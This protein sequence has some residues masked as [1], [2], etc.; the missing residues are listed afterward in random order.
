MSVP[1]RQWRIRFVDDLDDGLV[2]RTAAFFDEYFPGVFGETC[3]PELFRWK[4][5]PSNPAG[6]GILAVAVADDGEET[7]GVM[8]ATMKQMTVEGRSVLGAEVGDSFTNPN[9]RRA[10]RAAELSAG[11]SADH[12]LNRSVFGRLVDEVRRSLFDQNVEIVYG[13]PNDQALPGWCRRGGYA[14]APT[15]SA[16]SW[17]CPQPSIF[18]DRLPG[19]IGQITFAA[20][21]AL[22]SRPRRRLKTGESMTTISLR[23]DTPAPIFETI[24]RLWRSRPPG[25]NVVLIQDG[26]WIRHRYALHPSQSYDLHLVGGADRPSA[27]AISRTIT[28]SHGAT[29][30]C[31]TEWSPGLSIDGRRF[32]ELLFMV[33]ENARDVDTVSAWTNQR[34]GTW[35]RMV[36]AG[37]IPINSVPVVLGCNDLGRHIIDRAIP[38]PLPIGWSDN[39]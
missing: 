1:D 17:H 21:D 38:F 34:P 10:G 32:S 28:R 33:V 30:L 13:V 20:F 22:R 36:R 15:A 12:Y 4:L 39:V 37:F 35:M 5:G 8:T 16:Q 19:R 9:F 24:D 26:D 14:V 27:F 23:R 18:A 29:T 11:T 31:L 2:E 7:A 6:R 25:G 3:D